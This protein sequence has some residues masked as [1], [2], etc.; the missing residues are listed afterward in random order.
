MDNYC[1]DCLKRH[2][3]CHGECDLYKAYRKW[4][5][6]VNEERNKRMREMQLLEGRKIDRK[7]RRKHKEKRR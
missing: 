5:D 7:A 4:L 6:E 2:I 1:K 3:G